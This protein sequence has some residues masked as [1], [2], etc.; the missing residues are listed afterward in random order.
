MNYWLIVASEGE[1]QGREVSGLEKI[2]HRIKDRFFGV[3]E[4]KRYTQQ[5]SKGDKVVFYAAGDK[6]FVGQ[7]EVLGV[8]LDENE[9]A[10]DGWS[11]VSSSPE[12]GIGIYFSYADLW[13]EYPLYHDLKDKLS[14]INPKNPGFSLNHTIVKMSAA[15]YELLTG[16]A[17]ELEE[18]QRL[19]VLAP[20]LIGE[21]RLRQRKERVNQDKFRLKVLEYWDERCAVLG[22][23]GTSLL[24]A[25]HIKPWRACNGEEKVDPFNGLSL[26]PLLNHLFDRGLL[27]F[28][29]EGYVQMSSFLPRATSDLLGLRPSMRLRKIDQRHLEFLAFHRKEVFRA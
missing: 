6:A 13:L 19:E 16:T 28:S 10:P 11:P 12:T 23:P 21:E 20:G 4:G 15:D 8:R 7:A 14:F 18:D 3:G 17:Q 27:T 24:T 2:E 26:S 25:S 5:I 22:I 1:F 29:D 9:L